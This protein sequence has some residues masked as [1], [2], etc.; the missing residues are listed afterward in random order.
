MKRLFPLTAVCMTTALAADIPIR[1][2]ILYKSGVG[3]F[4]RAGTL[5]PADSA[6]LDFKAS[7]MNDVLKSLTLEDRNGG[8]ISGLRYD[9]SEPLQQKLADFPF[10]IGDHTALSLFLDQM[11]GAR[12]EIKYGAETVSGVIVGGRLVAADD[13]HSEREQAVLLLDS[14]DL[15]TLDLAAAGSIRFA[16]PKLQAQ[17]K[18]YLTIV[19]QSRSL[20]KRSIYIDSSDAKERQIEASYMI[21][22]PVWKSS[23]RLIF[24]D[25]TEPTLEGWA[26][27]DNTTGEDWTNVLLSVVSG[28]P[29]SFISK[30]YEPK[31][32]PRQTVELPEDR[33]AAPVV[34]QGALGGGRAEIAAASGATPPPPPAAPAFRAAQ[35]MGAINGRDAVLKE[36]TSNIEVNVASGDLGELFEYRFSTPVTVKK[37]E[38]AMLPFLQQK[39]GSRKLLIYSENYGEHPMN[40]AEL[41]NSTGK[42]LDG[43]PIT[44]FDANSYAGEALMTTLK[45]SDK[46]LISYAVDLGTRVTTQFDSSRNVV[47]EIHVN[48]G[49]LTA[50]SAMQ[51]TKTYTI[52]NVDQR[53]KTLIIEHAERPEYKLLSQKPA[54][55]TA[56][57]YRFEVKL[58]ADSTEKF[59]VNEERVYD[60]TTAVSSLTPDVLLTYVQNK[61]ISDAA[62]RQLQQI[63]DLKKQIAGQDNEIRQLDGDINNLIQDQNRIRQNITSLNQVSGQQDQVQKYARQLATQESQL[64]GMRDHQ[65]DLKKQRTTAESSLSALI[66]KLD[67]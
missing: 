44:V 12:V 58:G 8:K 54:E 25:K 2:V 30:L 27:I 46:R 41:T 53:P 14:G 4:E 17:L 18:D 29:V 45:A 64:A 67:F 37:D 42:A 32:V 21:P 38:S 48:R 56:N 60:T 26:I 19:N 35:I 7:D 20:D 59:P 65:S 15:R 5:R 9:S 61:A 1:E 33:A 52:R 43:G 57:A 62:R 34:Y 40:A 22:T 11:K 3:Y 39:I 10:K 16:D 23:Y 51:E 6:R 49:M 50:R 66:E 28:R 63:L 31:Y 36:P 47:R 55:T 24:N 13:K